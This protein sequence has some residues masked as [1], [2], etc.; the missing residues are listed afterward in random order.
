MGA[1]ARRALVRE[2]SRYAN[3]NRVDPV[4][5]DF[6][7]RFFLDH[8]IPLFFLIHP[9]TSSESESDCGAQRSP[10]YTNQPVGSNLWAYKEKSV[11][12]MMGLKRNDIRFVVAEGDQRWWLIAKK[13]TSASW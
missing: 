1:R 8:V 2:K 6:S 10:C 13:M 4:E 3:C 7:L 12:R 11:H 9:T 5:R